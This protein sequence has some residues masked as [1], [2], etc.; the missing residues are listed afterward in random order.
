[1]RSKGKKHYGTKIIKGIQHHGT[2]T[3]YGIPESLNGYTGKLTL[4]FSTKE[5]AILREE[6]TG[7][8]WYIIVNQE[9]FPDLMETIREPITASVVCSVT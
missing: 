4:T 1:M 5:H 9:G 8:R 7:R 3:M 2:K 6:S